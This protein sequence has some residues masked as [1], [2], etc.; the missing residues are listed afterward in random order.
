[1]ELLVVIGIIAVLI[2]ILLPTIGAAR[3]QAAI[4]KC[5]SNQHQLV[6]ATM[7]HANEHAGYFPLAGELNLKYVTGWD[8]M[9]SSVQ[10]SARK[11]YTYARWP[12]INTFAIVPFPAAVATY[13]GYRNL[14]FSDANKLDQQLNDREKGVWKMFMCP[15]TDSFDF[16]RRFAGSDTTPINQG[17]FMSILNNGSAVGAW[18]TNSDVAVNEGALGF[19]FDPRFASRRMAGN[20]T[21]A[22]NS[23][24]ILIFADAV[25]GTAAAYFFM[26]D[27]WICFRP[28]LISTG[29]VT[30][31]DVLAKNSKVTA[32]AQFDL[33]RHNKKINVAFADG[34]V[35]LVRIEPGDLSRVYLLPR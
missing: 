17:T 7:M 9:P 25:R 10:D 16:R 26:D 29:P 2:G 11:R 20:I 13:M 18:S 22:K 19:H 14:D 31:A 15:G 35:E 27:P 8:G 3:R 6:A 32:G 33:K 1:V 24:Q 12:E 23:S 4:T 34:H 5:S 21:R 30:L 28:S